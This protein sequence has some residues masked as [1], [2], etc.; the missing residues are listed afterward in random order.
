MHIKDTGKH[1]KHPCIYPIIKRSI[2]P[3]I[4]MYNKDSIENV[5][6]GENLNGF[7]R[8]TP[9]YK[10]QHHSLATL[11]GQFVNH[12]DLQLFL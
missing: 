12:G 3:T 1:D 5:P 11:Q 7:T 9:S 2:Y 4:Y 6:T 10:P 8:G